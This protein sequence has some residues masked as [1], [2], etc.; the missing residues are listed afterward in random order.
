MFFDFTKKEGYT[1][2]ERVSAY[3]HF[4]DISERLSSYLLRDS[5]NVE[6]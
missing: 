6:N 4:L 1:F 2:P 5:L 3:E